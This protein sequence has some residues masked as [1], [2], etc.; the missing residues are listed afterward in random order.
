[1]WL[2][3]CR[4]KYTRKT[5]VQRKKNQLKNTSK[6]TELTH[7]NTKCALRHNY[8]LIQITITSYYYSTN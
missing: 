4:K 7:R 2:K 5:R 1:M 6:L 3:P 8:L